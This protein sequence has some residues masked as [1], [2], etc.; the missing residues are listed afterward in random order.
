MSEIIRRNWEI[1]SR[2]KTTHTYCTVFMNFLATCASYAS[3]GGRAEPI[4]RTHQTVT[5]M[6]RTKTKPS[7]ASAAS[8]PTGGFLVAAIILDT[9][10]VQTTNTQETSTAAQTGGRWRT[11]T[12]RSSAAS[13]AITGRRAS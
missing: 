5:A 4:V 13:T 9:I 7:R 12:I 3:C 8:F 1:R 2:I 10:T 6:R 11:S